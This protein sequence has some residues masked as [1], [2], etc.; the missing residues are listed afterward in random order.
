[1]KLNPDCIRDI[2]LFVEKYT[3]TKTYIKFERSDNVP[4][5]LSNYSKDVFLYHVDQCKNFGFVLYDSRIPLTF[6][7]R[8]TD[9]SPKGHIFFSKY[10]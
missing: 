6:L 10:T 8:I 7:F 9:L 1:M 5:E 2:L 3:N 4:T